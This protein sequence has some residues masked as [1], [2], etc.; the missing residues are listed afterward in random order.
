MA[1]TLIEDYQ[2]GSA[3]NF[4]IELTITIGF[5]QLGSTS[6]SIDGKPITGK[7]QSLAGVDILPTPNAN[8]P[9]SF[10]VRI[11]KNSELAGKQ[12][13]II[14]S[15]ARIQANEDRSSLT[16]SLKGGAASQTFQPLEESIP[17]KGDWIDYV[18]VI[19]FTA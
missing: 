13:A 12:L 7:A 6:L 15:V 17:K 1:A 2:L 3:S 10:K 4:P 5:A 8:Y 19:T 14:S 18:A 11:G 16:V 9:G